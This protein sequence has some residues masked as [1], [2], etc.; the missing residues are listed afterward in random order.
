MKQRQVEVVGETIDINEEDDFGN[1][2]R[3]DK[4]EVE[5]MSVGLNKIKT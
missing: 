3:R 5:A 1:L 4:K 2:L